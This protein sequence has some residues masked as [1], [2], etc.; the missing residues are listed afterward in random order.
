[1][2]QVL[3]VPLLSNGEGRFCEPCF[4]VQNRLGVLLSLLFRLTCENEYL[5][6]MVCILVELFDRFL[7][8]ARVIVALRQAQPPAL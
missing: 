5:A 4:N 6:Y 2:I 8:S 1:M 3:R 7:I